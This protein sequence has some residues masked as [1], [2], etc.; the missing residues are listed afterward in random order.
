M[1]KSE[2]VKYRNLEKWI[3]EILKNENTKFGKVKIRNSEIWKIWNL[4]IWKSENLKFWKFEKW[5]LENRKCEIW[6]NIILGGQNKE[7]AYSRG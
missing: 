2:N 4:D 1:W 6:E 7:I 5:N 3:Y